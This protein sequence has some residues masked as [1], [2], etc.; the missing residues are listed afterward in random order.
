MT[1]NLWAWW[2]KARTAP[3]LVGTAEL[4]VHGDTPQLG[5]YRMQRGNSKG[6]WEPVCLFLSGADMKARIGPWKTGE[7]VPAVD[8]WSKCCKFPIYKSRNDAH[9]GSDINWDDVAL[10]GKPWP[11][12]VYKLIETKP[13]PAPAASGDESETTAGIGHNSGEA[14]PFSVLEEKLGKL[15]VLIEADVKKLGKPS[16]TRWEKSDADRLQN[17]ANMIAVLEKD[18]STARDAAV[19]PLKA[20][21]DAEIAKWRPMIDRPDKKRRELKALVNEYAGLKQAQEEAEAAAK[22]EAERK[23]VEAE[24]AAVPEELQDLIPEPAAPVKVERVMI[25][26]AGTRTAYR[27]PSAVFVI[28]DIKLLAAEIAAMD[29]V[30]REFMDACQ[31]IADKVGRAGVVLKGVRKDG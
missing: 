11:D 27:P 8:V 16:L 7:I 14:D 23:R 5:Y 10:E 6:P 24:R 18:I 30:P 13:D 28:T 20:A 4:P 19:R 31:K 1:N 29:T 12:S 17:S 2:M 22:A 21:W 15:L 25:G 9:P 26:T 3:H